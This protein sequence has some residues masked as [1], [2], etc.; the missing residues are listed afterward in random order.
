MMRSNLTWARRS[1]DP[2]AQPWFWQ[3]AVCPVRIPQI[4][5]IY[6]LDLTINDTDLQS[7]TTVPAKAPL[8]DI[9]ACSATSAR[10][11]RHAHHDGGL[12]RGGENTSPAGREAP[13]SF[14]RLLMLPGWTIS[15]NALWARPVP[16]IL[17]SQ[18]SGGLAATCRS[19][20][21]R[22]CRNRDRGASA[23]AAWLFYAAGEIAAP[24]RLA[25]A[26]YAAELMPP[27]I[28]PI[29]RRG[30]PLTALGAARLG[31]N[32]ERRFGARLG[33]RMTTLR[34]AQ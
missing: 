20:R 22:P 28:D 1:G 34:S 24:S 11:R 27:R 17:R 2:R 23:Y 31:T 25:A 16:P 10:L 13:G 9:A 7:A 30:P 21:L 26:T 4:A 6:Q 12:L 32:A 18:V 33:R 14:V 5:P 19:R 3:W 8:R 15:G 29:R